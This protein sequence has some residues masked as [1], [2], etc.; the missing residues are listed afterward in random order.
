MKSRESLNL[1]VAG[2]LLMHSAYVILVPIVIIQH[3]LKTSFVFVQ[4]QRL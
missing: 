3:G 2:I 4:W 1:P